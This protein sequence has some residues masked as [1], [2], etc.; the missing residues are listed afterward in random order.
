MKKIVALLCAIILCISICACN[1]EKTEEEKLSKSA[2]SCQELIQKIGEVTLDSEENITAAE[3]AY[4]KLS[5]DDKKSIENSFKTLKDA[6]SEYDQL[7]KQSN[8]DIVVEAIDKIGTVSLDSESNINDARTK[9]DELADEEKSLVSNYNN[10]ET[11]ES[12]LKKLKDKEKENTYNKYKSKFDIENDKVEGITWYYHDNMPEYIDIRSY[13]IPY[14]GVRHNEPWICVRYNY[15]N[16]NWI[17]WNKLTIVADGEKF[18]K[19][20]SSFDTVRDNEGG[21]VWEYYDEIFDV[22]AKMDSAD[23]KMLK[24]IAESDE[25]I[26][27]FE[28]DDYYY[29]LTVTNTDKNTIKDVLKIYSS[30]I[31]E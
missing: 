6:R 9:Y 8:A 25:T 31:K 27:R 13:I 3:Q 11:A 21:L 29:D 24:A 15:T 23:I 30:L 20:I 2:E 19:T 7:V 14:I 17:F 16:D 5:D 10:L 1:N 28:G 12:E 18:Y 22:N 26:I 4:N